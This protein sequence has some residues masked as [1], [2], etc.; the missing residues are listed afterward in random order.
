MSTSRG[1]LSL[2]RPEHDAHGNNSFCT[3]KPMQLRSVASLRTPFQATV[4]REA[5]SLRP[6]P[7]GGPQRQRR[8][9]ERALPQMWSLSLV[10]PRIRRLK[11]RAA[12]P[13]PSSTRLA[14][15]GIVLPV[16]ENVALKVGGVVP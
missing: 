15:S 14:G 5:R 6:Y 16:T 4:A 10:V 13:T 12:N 7:T 8:G 3:D 9:R 1:V 11:R 2:C